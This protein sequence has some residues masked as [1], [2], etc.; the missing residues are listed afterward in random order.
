MLRKNRY[1]RDSYG[2]FE[3]FSNHLISKFKYLLQML[4]L[5]FTTFLAIAN[6]VVLLDSQKKIFWK[7]NQE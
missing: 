4:F 7:E 1:L 5:S 3:F 2:R 6:V